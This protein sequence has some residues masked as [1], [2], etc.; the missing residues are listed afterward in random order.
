M[1]LEFSYTVEVDTPPGG[2]MSDAE[3]ERLLSVMTDAIDNIVE[4][5]V[6]GPYSVPIIKPVRASLGVITREEAEGGQREAV[7]R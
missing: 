4:N 2:A 7:A 6:F 5:D 3:R 1:R